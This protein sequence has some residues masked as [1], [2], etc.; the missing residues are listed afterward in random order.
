MFDLCKQTKQ[1]VEAKKKEEEKQYND[2]VANLT[3]VLKKNPDDKTM[4][5]VELVTTS[6]NYYEKTKFIFC[7]ITMILIFFLNIYTGILPNNRT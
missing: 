1:I 3:T 5:H 4:H 7:C 2:F 6:F